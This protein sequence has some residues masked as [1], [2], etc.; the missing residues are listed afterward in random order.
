MI[1]AFPYPTLFGDITLRVVSVGVDGDELPY[2]RISQAART[3]A[4]HQAGR[5]GWENAVLRVKVTVPDS[6]LVEGPWTDVVFIAVLSEKATNARTTAV[7]RR[8]PGEA[9]RAQSSWTAHGTSAA[10]RL[11]SR[12]SRPSTVSPGV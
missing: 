8:T 9:S 2:Q 6:E 3:V 7:L 1:A 5:D 11:T 10:S 4:L 12:S